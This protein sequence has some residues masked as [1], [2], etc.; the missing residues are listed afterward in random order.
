MTDQKSS[1]L[2]ITPWGKETP[3]KLLPLGKKSL[4][5]AHIALYKHQPK[6]DEKI[7]FPD[8]IDL[9]SL[10]GPVYDQGQIGSCVA[11]AFSA[12][13]RYLLRKEG[14]TVINPSRLFLYLVTRAYI[15]G[16][17]PLT[18]SGSSLLQAIQ[19]GVKYGVCTN[20]LWPYDTT[21]YN[22][23]PPS[24][25]F[26]DA[27]NHKVV[28]YAT[29]NQDANSIISCL[30]NGYPVVIGIEVYQ[31]F[32][33]QTVAETGVVPLP[34]IQTETLLGGHALC[35]VGVN[36]TAK[37]FL[38]QN[39]WGNWGAK[40]LCTLPYDYVLNPQ[41]TF[42]LWVVTEFNN[43]SSVPKQKKTSSLDDH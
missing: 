8:I 26:Q 9:S 35:L 15:V 14:Q 10:T 7:T 36:Q 6:P 25:C 11:N 27:L 38:I 2:T 41:L 28:T 22:E 30:H 1:V 32:E 4:V 19:A 43:L 12:D 29:V 18:D 23:I 13:W 31:S 16:E 33:S 37:T 42:E 3:Y 20:I 17:N 34:N 21:K 5:P 24:K 39:S 40:G